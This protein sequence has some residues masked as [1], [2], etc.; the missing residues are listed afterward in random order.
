M[1]LVLVISLVLP[2]MVLSAL[3]GIGVGRRIRGDLPDTERAQ[4]YGMQASLLGLLA[5]LLGFSFAMAET[6]FE[7]RKQLVVDETN[8]IGTARLRATVV[9]DEHGR[10]IQQLLDDYIATRLA[11]YQ[12]GD[13]A[14]LQA[15]ID[16]SLRPQGEMW[17]RVTAIVRERPQSLPASLL[18]QALNDV[19]DLHTKRVAAGRNHVPTSVLVMLLVVAAVTMG[20]VGAGVGIGNRRGTVTALLLSLLISLVVGVILDMDAPRAGVIR[21]TQT[22]LGD[23]QRSLQ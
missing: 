23:L 18:M 15:A 20:W 22:T 16:R 6:R 9:D 10:A 13:A 7:M 14:G 17:T 8:A 21:V 19:I 5:L 4:L 12:A 3:V 11:G 1:P 2:L